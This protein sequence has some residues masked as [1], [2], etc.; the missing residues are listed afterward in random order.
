MFVLWVL[1]LGYDVTY[2][3]L[4]YPSHIRCHAPRTEV[5]IFKKVG[6]LF[7]SHTRTTNLDNCRLL[8]VFDNLFLSQVLDV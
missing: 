3:L 6:N 1:Q 2:G 5:S 8:P 7:H 4:G